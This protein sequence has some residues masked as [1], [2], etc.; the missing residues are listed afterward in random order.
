M[1]GPKTGGGQ[2]GEITVLQDEE[3]L[4]APQRRSCLVPGPITSILP[5]IGTV[6]P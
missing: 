2:Y 6:L 3:G 5:T 1:T 4:G